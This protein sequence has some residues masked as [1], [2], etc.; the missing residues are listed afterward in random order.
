MD[1]YRLLDFYTEPFSNSPDPEFFFGSS[2]HMDCLQK[3]EISIRLKRGLCVVMGEV[4]AGK[5]TICRKLIRGLKD[6]PDIE[7]HL[8]LDPSFMSSLEM[9]G[10][11]NRMMRKPG[12]SERAPCSEA[13]YKE[14]IKNHLFQKVVKEEK[15]VVLIVDEGQKISPS[16]LEVLRELLNFETNESKLLQI[17]IFAQNEFQH[18]LARHTNF[19]DRVNLF[20]HVSPLSFQETRALIRYRIEKATDYKSSRRPGISLTTRAYKKIYLITRGHP[21]KIIN[22][23][24]RLLLLL[25]VTNKQ[26]VTASMVEKAAQSLARA[27]KRFYFQR[28]A[29]SW[30][31]AATLLLVLGVGYLFYPEFIDF[32]RNNQTSSQ[33][34][35]SQYS[36]AYVRMKLDPLPRVNAES[37]IM[38]EGPGTEKTILTQNA[39]KHSR[40][41]LISPDPA[42][43]FFIPDELGRIKIRRHENL[44]NILERVYGRASISLVGKVEALNPHISNINHLY[45][46][47]MVFLPVLETSSPSAG[48]SY[49]IVLDTYPGL[50][51]AYTRLLSIDKDRLRVLPYVDSE[52]NVLYSVVWPRSF[53]SENRVLEETNNLPGHMKELSGILHLDDKA[54]LLF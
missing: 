40:E 41:N 2:S 36:P 15:N 53:S 31:I 5:T 27:K 43:A 8:I 35:D 20:C 16:C 52:S 51:E 28:Q 46:G 12:P 4:G 3:L 42:N 21:R 38:L 25:I 22:L 18:I 49:W 23:C 13:G 45:E 34:Q 7:A 14:L 26:K 48:E 39:N 44:W 50:E 24:H 37:I 11:L 6:D 47:Q 30:G 10:S 1:Y 9:L 32:S 19:A 33:I 17:I 29:F 54:V